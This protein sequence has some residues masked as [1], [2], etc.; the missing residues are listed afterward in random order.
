MSRFEKFQKIKVFK[1][2]KPLFEQIFVNDCI[3]NF[4]DGCISNF[5]SDE[6]IYQPAIECSDAHIEYWEKG[7]LHKNVGPAVIS[8]WGD[9]H[10]YWNKGN[11]KNI[12]FGLKAEENF[13]KYLNENS[14]PF[15]HI[16]QING[17]LYSKAF[18]E[19]DIKIKRPDYTVFIDKKPYF[20]DVKA[21]SFYVN[22]VYTIDKNDIERLNAL[23]K[24]YNIKVL[25]AITNINDISFNN[26]SFLTLDNLNKYIKYIKNEIYKNVEKMFYP[27]HIDILSNGNIKDTINFELLDNNMHEL[28][29]NIEW[30]ELKNSNS[31]CDIV[32]NYLK[33]NN[34]KLEDR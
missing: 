28:T 15:M 31:Y 14:I 27:F 32:I 11:L 20:I 3:I 4:V 34:Y 26:F 17:K 18:W 21:K 5:L 30:E 22:D 29:K 19:N 6:D 7:L 12:E 2:D 33:E 1:D 9:K 10:E 13:A 16:D 8:L 25:L 23:D 24:E